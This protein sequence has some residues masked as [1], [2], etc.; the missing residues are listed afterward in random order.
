ML[1]NT[2]NYID[3]NKELKDVYK[4]N[5]DSIKDTIKEIKDDVLFNKEE[6]QEKLKE[7]KIDLENLKKEYKDKK[8]ELKKPVSFYVMFF[9][10]IALIAGIIGS[11]IYLIKHHRN[12]ENEYFAFRY[13]Q[14]RIFIDDYTEIANMWLITTGGGLYA[15]SSI[16]IGYTSD[17]KD[18]EVEYALYAMQERLGGTKSDEE[19]EIKASYAYDNYVLTLDNNTSYRILSKSIKKDDKILTILFSN[20]GDLSDEEQAYLYQIYDTIK[21][22]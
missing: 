14:E 13:N 3:K 5:I 2:K 7:L 21:L 19:S 18:I 10:V 9:I 17:A 1:Q 6:K 11:E 22:K 4:N 15:P 20:A 16:L 8:K 12:Y